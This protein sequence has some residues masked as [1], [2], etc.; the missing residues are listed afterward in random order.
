VLRNSGASHF[1][2]ADARILP[3]PDLGLKRLSK[4]CRVGVNELRLEG[5]LEENG[6]LPK[7]MPRHHFFDRSFD[8]FVV[9]LRRVRCYKPREVD[10]IILYRRAT[11]AL[12]V[13]WRIK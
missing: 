6:D 5:M 2:F 8:P 10:R 13:D 3:M 9:S 12:A 11:G 7:Q 4:S 1:K